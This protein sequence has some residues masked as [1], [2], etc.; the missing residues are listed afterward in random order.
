MFKIFCTPMNAHIYNG[1]NY[2]VSEDHTMVYDVFLVS[3]IASVE[4]KVIASIGK[5]KIQF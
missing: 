4:F 1:Y 2:I 5:A 3:I